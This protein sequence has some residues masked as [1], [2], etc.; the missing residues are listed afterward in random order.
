MNCETNF[1]GKDFR[2]WG[3]KLDSDIDIK[4]VSPSLITVP[5]RF[6]AITVHLPASC[7]CSQA[8]I[9]YHFFIPRVSVYTKLYSPLFLT[10]KTYTTYE[11]SVLTPLS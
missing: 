9:L 8:I 11:Y 3:A 1:R 6:I 2:R 4:N 5:D 7:I 10:P